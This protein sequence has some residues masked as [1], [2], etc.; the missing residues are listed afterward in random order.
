MQPGDL[1]L[2]VDLEAYLVQNIHKNTV[3]MRRT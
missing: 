3:E 2:A 1:L